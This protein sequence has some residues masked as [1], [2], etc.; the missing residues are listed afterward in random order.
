MHS[1]LSRVKRCNLG[2][3]PYILDSHRPNRGKVACSHEIAACLLC[4]SLIDN[5]DERLNYS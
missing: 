4:D 5:L 3:H 1:L 2:P